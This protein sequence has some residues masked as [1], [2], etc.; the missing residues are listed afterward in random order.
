MSLKGKKIIVGMTG[1]IAAYKIPTLVRLFKKSSAEV[2]VVMTANATKFITT[3]TMETVSQNPVAL[4]MFP[5]DRFVGTHHIDLADWPDLIIVAPATANFMAKV[6][7][8]IC[9]DLLSTVICATKTPVVIAPAMNTNMYLNPITQKNLDYLKS[10]GYKFIEPGEGELACNTFGKGRM[11]EPEEIF[12]FISN[13]LQ[14]K[15]L[16]TDKKVLVT[17][18]PCR[19]P[20]DPVRF[21]SNRSSGKMGYAIASAANE[22]GAEVSLISG[23]TN[24]NPESGIKRRMVETTEEMFREVKK[25]FAISDIIIMAA[26]PADFKAKKESRQKIKKGIKDL[27]IELTSTVDILSSLRKSKKKGQIVVGFALETENGIANAR[28][29]M[30]EKGMDLIVLNMVGEK[31][32]FDSEDNK[33]TLVYK[34]GKQEALPLMSKKE[35]ANLLIKRI[36]KLK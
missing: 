31:A 18:G 13:Q 8:G 17:A 1:G 24:L 36:A 34:N 25:E 10:L 30:K 2:R 7:S 19:E 29:K 27:S 33:V 21:I 23:P 28:A 15:K 20:I 16:L 6:A 5:E 4:E 35:L 32:P 11:A 22:A 26:A 12:S 14:K 3:L 9:D